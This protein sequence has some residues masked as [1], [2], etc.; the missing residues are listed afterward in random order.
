MGSNFQ[1]II[2]GLKSGVHKSIG[3]KYKFDQRI[4]SINYP[5]KSRPLNLKRYFYLEFPSPKLKSRRLIFPLTT[6]QKHSKKAK[7]SSSFSLKSLAPKNGRRN[8]R[9]RSRPSGKHDFQAY[10]SSIFSLM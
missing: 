10:I 1:I 8:G 2:E 3:I 6:K 5:V 7:I 9:N 4:Y